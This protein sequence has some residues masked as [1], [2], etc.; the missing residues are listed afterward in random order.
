[1]KKNKTISLD[2]DVIELLDYEDNA[3]Q[4][5]NDLLHA[6]FNTVGSTQDLNKTKEELEQE[7][8]EAKAKLINITK[9]E[10][11]INKALEQ[12]KELSI[13]KEKE[14]ALK[15]VS[16]IVCGNK[17]DT[18]NSKLFINAGEKG[19]LHKSCYLMLTPELSSQIFKRKEQTEQITE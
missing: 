6:H 15:S 1:M 11:E 10:Q 3:S 16:C 2:V 12:A 19:L 9:Q 5:I 4:L 8:L 18:G 14:I 13:A 17:V 7:K